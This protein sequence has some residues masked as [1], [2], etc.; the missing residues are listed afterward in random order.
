MATVTGIVTRGK[1]GPEFAIE[2]TLETLDGDDLFALLAGTGRQP[3]PH[4]GKRITITIT[5]A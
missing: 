5:E 3:G 1:W 4:D 2:G